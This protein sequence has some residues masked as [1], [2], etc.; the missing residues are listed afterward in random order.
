MNDGSLAAASDVGQRRGRRAGASNSD[1]RRRA[2]A[3]DFETLR[4]TQTALP[5]APR[6]ETCKTRAAGSKGGRRRVTSKLVTRRDARTHST[7]ARTAR[8]HSTQH[9]ARTHARTARTARTNARAVRMHRTHERTHARTHSTHSTHARCLTH[10]QH[11]R[12]AQHARSRST[13]ACT[14]QHAQ[15]APHARTHSTHKKKRS[16]FCFVYMSCSH[17]NLWCINGSF[18]IKQ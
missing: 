10:A 16:V 11:A 13:H 18:S 4:G 3:S 5:G 15:H 9:F 7:H 8:T 12:T 14:A 6:L 17:N 2:A 1:M